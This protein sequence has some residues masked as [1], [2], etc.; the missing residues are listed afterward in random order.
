[1]NAS[2][3]SG[4]LLVVGSVV[5]FI[6]AAIGVPGVFTQR[7]PDVRLRMLEARARSWVAAQPLYGSGA[8]ICALGVAVLSKDAGGTARAMLAHSFVLLFVGSLAWGSLYKRGTDIAAFARG[9][10]AAWP[11]ASY[12]LATIAGLVLL[13]I[14]LLLGDFPTWL[15]WLVIAADAVFLGGY[16]VRG[17]PTLRLLC[18]APHRGRDAPVSGV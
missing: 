3:A 10:L 5:F 6:G 15:S 9:A 12:V 8:I 13:G 7:D 11:F 16:P 1:M 14:G 17:H 2:Q 18:A 4:L